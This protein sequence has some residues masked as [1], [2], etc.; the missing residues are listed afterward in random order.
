[1][2]VLTIIQTIMRARAFTISPDR[3]SP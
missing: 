3:K 2:I 1:M